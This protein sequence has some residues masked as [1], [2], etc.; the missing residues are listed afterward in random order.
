M[1]QY[2]FYDYTDSFSFLKGILI[3]KYFGV[4]G[5]IYTADCWKTI[6]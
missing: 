4:N 3:Q 5:A 1:G 6:D 2:S